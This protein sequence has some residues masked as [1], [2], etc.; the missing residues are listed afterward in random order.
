MAS[1]Y[2]KQDSKFIWIRYK[3]ENGKW[4]GK[5]SGYPKGNERSNLGNVRQAELLARE[6]TQKEMAQRPV[7]SGR[8]GFTEWVIPWVEQRWGDKAGGRTLKL[9]RR[10]FLRWMD[11]LNEVGAPLPAAVTRD[12]VLG[13]FPWR[14]ARGGERNTALGELKFFSQVLDEA[15]RRGYTPHNPALKLGMKRAEV[16]HKTPWTLKQTEIALDAAEKQ[17]KFGWL[18]VSILMGFYQ[19]VRSGQCRVPLNCIDLDRRVINYPAH[20]MKSGRPHSQPIDP[21]FHP[22]LSEIVEHRRKLNKTTLADLPLLRGVEMRRF[23]DGLIDKDA[24]F[25]GISHHGLRTAWITRAALSEGK[26][27]ETFAKRFVDHASTEIHEIYQR[28]SA[29]DLSS[30]FAHL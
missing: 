1:T 28:I 2:T 15:V 16:E 14:K 30:M 8:S 23:L 18:H 11:Y 6:M 3:D 9:Y 10:Y 21:K 7:V 20:V 27:T 5:N 4:K 25:S 19:A 24:G 13:Y 29:T 12:I 26:I 17:D 22:I